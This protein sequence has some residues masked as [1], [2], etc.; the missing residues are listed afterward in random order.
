MIPK[1]IIVRGG[2]Y[3]CRIVKMYLKLRDQQ[4]KTI[5]YKYRLLYK[6]LMVTTSQKSIIDTQ[7]KRKGIQT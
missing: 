5:M 6:Y 2:E 3:K 4:H 1:I 7:K